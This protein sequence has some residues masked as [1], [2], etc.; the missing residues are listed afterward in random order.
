MARKPFNKNLSHA[1]KY[2]INSR[3]CT[4]TEILCKY[5]GVVGVNDS[6]RKYKYDPLKR[7]PLKIN[8]TQT[9]SAK[10]FEL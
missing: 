4:D 2:C 10:D 6:C 9:Y 8:Q 1:C 7:E 3:V 5:K